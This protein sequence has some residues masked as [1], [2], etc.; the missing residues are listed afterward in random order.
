MRGDG[1]DEERAALA[2]DGERGPQE[3]RQR[4]GDAEDDERAAQAEARDEG[5]A[6]ERAGDGGGDADVLVDQADLGV[7]KAE[8]EQERRRHGGGDEI[9]QPVERDEG[10]QRE[11]ARASEPV[12]ERLDD[13]GAQL[14]GGATAAR[15]GRDQRGDDADGEQ[16]G[17]EL[18]HPTER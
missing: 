11:R 1:D 5:A 10:E 4:H 6:A 16:R 15:L 18:V 14:D 17:R 2:G 7:R 13:G 12:G 8:R 3:V 9:A